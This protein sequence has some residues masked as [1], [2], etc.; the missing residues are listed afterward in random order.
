MSVLKKT[1]TVPG[2]SK[3]LMPMAE[4]PAVR[5]VLAVIAAG[6]LAYGFWFGRD[7]DV[8]G[9]AIAAALAVGLLLLVVAL[10]GQLP[11][12]LKVG[13]IEVKLD[14]VR[15]DGL[16]DGAKMAAIAAGEVSQDNSEMAAHQALRS[17]RDPDLRNRTLH[18]V[19]TAAEVVREAAGT[20]PAALDDRKGRELMA[21]LATV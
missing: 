9:V 7:K 19:C 2:E 20:E 12:S 21:K 14:Q 17:I 4:Q 10:A 11:S 16:R 3:A 18:A 15:A 1:A 8:D 6:A 13:D 5:W